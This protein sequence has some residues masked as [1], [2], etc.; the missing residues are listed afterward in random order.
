MGTTSPTTCFNQFLSCVTTSTWQREYDQTAE[1]YNL[2]TTLAQIVVFVIFTVNLQLARIF[3]WPDY[4]APCFLPQSQDCR[5]GELATHIKVWMWVWIV[6]CLYNS[7]PCQL[8]HRLFRVFTTSCLVWAGIGSSSPQP[9]KAL[10]V[11]DSKWMH[12]FLFSYFKIQCLSHSNWADHLV[13]E[14]TGIFSHH[15]IPLQFQNSYEKRHLSNT[16]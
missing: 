14:M 13:V 16:N 1:T 9:S 2:F 4:F 8:C 10:M 12:G 6:A 11:M 3:C 7:P 15:L 5:L